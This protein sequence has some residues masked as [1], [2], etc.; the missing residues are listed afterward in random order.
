MPRVRSPFTP[1]D[2]GTGGY[3]RTDRSKATSFYKRRDTQR[4]IINKRTD[5]RPFPPL[6]CIPNTS[7]SIES[8]P[9]LALGTLRQESGGMKRRRRLNISQPY[10]PEYSSHPTAY[11][12]PSS[13]SVL[14]K[15]DLRLNLLFVDFS[16]MDDHSTGGREL[17]GAV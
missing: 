8:R 14:V 4:G 5:P 2:E 6:P 9:S 15:V 3:H 13:S 10:A 7:N 17:P 1:M 16:D 12:H 11:S